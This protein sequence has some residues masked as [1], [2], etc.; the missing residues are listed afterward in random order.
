[1]HPIDIMHRPMAVHAMAAVL[2]WHIP[3]RSIL[4]LRLFTL[5]VRGAIF[6]DFWLMGI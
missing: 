4:N 6:I 1:M 2:L 5:C 3:L